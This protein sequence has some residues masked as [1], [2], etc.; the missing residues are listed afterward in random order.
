M[1]WN[2]I[3]DVPPDVVVSILMG[4]HFSFQIQTFADEPWNVY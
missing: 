2:S 1:F 3:I 4:N